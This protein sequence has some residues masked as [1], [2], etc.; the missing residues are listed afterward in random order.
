[1][2]YSSDADE[3]PFL[4]GHEKRPSGPILSPHALKTQSEHRELELKAIAAGIEI[5]KMMGGREEWMVVPGKYDFLST[6]KS[7]QP[8]K[9]RGF[10][11]KKNRGEDKVSAPVHPAVQAEM[12][13]IMQAHQDSRGPSL[14]DQHRAAKQEE[15]KSAATTTQASSWTW[16]RESDLDAGRKVDKEALHMVLGGAADNLKTKFHGGF[17]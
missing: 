12:D 15:R 13:A 3:G 5:P 17:D 10:E 2:E 1:M 9:S 4:P 16:N 14:F 8:L 7:G 6:I 11:N